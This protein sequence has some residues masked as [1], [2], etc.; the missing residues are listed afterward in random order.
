M[1]LKALAFTS[2]LLLVGAQS[3]A[4][5]APDG[6]LTR[7]TIEVLL[8]SGLAAWNQSCPVR[9]T[10]GLCATAAAPRDKRAD[11]LSHCNLPAAVHRLHQIPRRSGAHAARA[12]LRKA[13]RLYYRFCAVTG[14]TKPP[15]TAGQLCADPELRRRVATAVFTLADAL[16]EDALKISMAAPPSGFDAGT[17][18]GK[19]WFRSHLDRR[20]AISR[21]ATDAYYT[22]ARLAPDELRFACIARI[23][24]VHFQSAV[25]I[26]AALVPPAIRRSKARVRAHCD[27]IGDKAAA[28]EEKA[29]DR[30][31]DCVQQAAS[32]RS[33]DAWVD[34]CKRRI[35]E[36]R[37]GA[38]VLKGEL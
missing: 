27:V 4:S 20:G 3:T 5:A 37:Q 32:R 13:W 6:P 11:N 7:R 17:P 16:F 33:T 34:F 1:K 8:S 24:E 36:I 38:R 19:R 21:P 12:R 14:V 31:V 18:I 15:A 10:K 26:W 30:F 25:D 28:F 22:A 9:T 23:G 2:A 29:A 35:A